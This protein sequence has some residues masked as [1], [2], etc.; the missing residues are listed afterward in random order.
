MIKFIYYGEAV[1]KGRP[2]YSTQGGYVHTYTPKKTKEF[3][4]AIQNAFL[5]E[6]TGAR[7]V[8]PEG[9]VLYAEILIGVS[10]PKSYSKRKREDCLLGNIAPTKKPDIDNII[11]SIFDA[12]NG[13]AYEDDSQIIQVYAHKKY[14]DEPYVDIL[15]GER[16]EI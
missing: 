11:K 13:L 15:I 12:L 8:Y 10:V 5:S 2:R 7:P 4:S 14:S 9:K 3:E 6:Y 1:G 16:C